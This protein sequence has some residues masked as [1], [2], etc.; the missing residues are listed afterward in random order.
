VATRFRLP[1]AGTPGQSPA[2]RIAWTH[3]PGTI[4]R[5]PMSPNAAGTAFAATTYTPDAADHLVA[6]TAH[7]A[8][9]ISAPLAAQTITAQTISMTMLA[10]VSHANNNLSLHWTVYAVTAAD[11]LVGTLVATRTDGFTI[12]ASQMAR[13][14]SATSTSVTVAAGDRLVFEVGLSGTPTATGGTQGHNGAIRFGDVGTDLAANDTATVDGNPWLD[15]AT[16]TLVFQGASTTGAATLVGRGAL[17]VTARKGSTSAATL[18]GR[19]VASA[20]AR[21][22]TTSAATFQARGYGASTS[23]TPRAGMASFTRT[24]GVAL[25]PGL[26]PDWLVD[27]LHLLLV[28]VGSSTPTLATPVGWTLLREVVHA[29]GDYIDAWLFWRR[30]QAGDTAPSLA[31]GDNAIT[32]PRGARIYGVRGVPPTEVDPFDVW[33]WATGE[34]TS[35]TL[36]FADITTTGLYEPVLA[37]AAW[38][39]NPVTV[40]PMSGWTLPDGALATFGAAPVGDSTTTLVDDPGVTVDA[41]TTPGVMLLHQSRTNAGPAPAGATSV[42]ISDATVGAAG[43]ATFVVAF[44][45]P[46]AAPLVISGAGGIGSGEAVGAPVVAPGPVAIVPAGIATAE[47]LG[48]PTLVP[49][50]VT[51]QGIGIA[52][53]QAFGTATLLRGAVAVSPAGIDSLEAFGGAFIPLVVTLSG[54]A[55]LEAFGT[56]LVAPGAVVVTPAGVASLGAFGTTSLLV[57][58]ISIQPSGLVTV[59]AFGAPL[60]AVGGVT[61]LLA[62]LASIEAF[63]GASV[64]AGAVLLAPSGIAT[65]E[66]VGSPLLTTYTWILTEIIPSEEA[67]GAPSVTSLAVVAP[68][69]VGSLEALGA[70]AVT[71][72]V[73]ILPVGIATAEALGSLQLVLGGVT[74][75]LTGLTTGEAFG[76]PLL[77]SGVSFIAPAAILP[78]EVF[79]GPLAI[80]GL[81]TVLPLGIGSG[82]VFGATTLVLIVSPAGLVS[83]EAIGGAVLAVGA[84]IIGPAGIVPGEAFGTGVVSAGEA[85]LLLEGIASDEVFGAPVFQ[86]RQ[87]ILPEGL[88]SEEGFGITLVVP[89]V[90]LILPPSLVT[91]EAFGLPLLVPGATPISVPGIDSAETV[92]VPDVSAPLLLVLLAIPSGEQFGGLTVLIPLLVKRVI[93]ARAVDA[94]WGQTRIRS[95]AMGVSAATDRDYGRTKALDAPG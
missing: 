23:D 33:S 79:G 39:E 38:A 75:L 51:I 15:F 31:F 10:L 85:A 64:S 34:P 55:T 37:L 9:F 41:A 95:E 48:T 65:V 30:A 67:F 11:A 19:G 59:E 68:L 26:P 18:G 28:A 6:G 5:L 57:G 32:I 29:T 45:T 24:S 21:K 90:S 12:N 17:G 16:T 74:L 47:A 87:D 13:T 71:T 61:L 49:G 1:S 93:R 81:V 27:D 50:G 52:S 88:L 66:Q 80:P 4:I 82:E 94:A 78:G 43:Y 86:Y 8:Q 22:D 69:G 14:D 7:I 42:S 35:T 60:L 62:G 63:G 77:Q 91:I 46:Y 44:K 25:T 56:A 58:A 73:T 89:D 53:L 84:P 76:G 20:T 36:A 2:L 54:L 72:L 83:V 70:T 40:T 3:V 92:G